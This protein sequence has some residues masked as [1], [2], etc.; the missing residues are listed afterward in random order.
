MR[1]IFVVLCLLFSA[2][3][4]SAQYF[5]FSQYNY[6]TQRVSPTAPAE[7][8]YARLTFLYRNQSTGGDINLNSNILSASYPLLNKKNGKRWSGI[9]ISIMDD[10]TGGVYQS[11][12]ASLAYA[13]NI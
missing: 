11:T 12:E 7:S 5:Q 6:A 13:V 10:R 3:S 2:V 8:D 1:R 9:G 4:G